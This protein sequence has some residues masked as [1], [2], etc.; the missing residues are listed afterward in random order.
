MPET[1]MLCVQCLEGRIGRRLEPSDF[2]TAFIND[3]RKN[4]KMSDQLRSRIQG[5]QYV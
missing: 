1:G 4:N 5:L 3:P 2:T